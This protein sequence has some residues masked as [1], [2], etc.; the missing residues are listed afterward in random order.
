[1]LD[2]K[3]IRDSLDIVE[4]NLKRR[5]NTENIKMLNEVILLDKKWR[6]K[7]E[8]TTKLRFE[9]NKISM[10][11]SKQKKEGKNIDNLMKQAI[12]IPKELDILEKETKKIQE[13]VKNILMKLPN[14]LHDSVPDGKD[15]SQNKEIKIIGKKPEFDFKPKDHFEIL[16]DLNMIDSESGAKAAGHAFFLFKR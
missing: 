13:N 1:M 10:E 15:E 3:L 8:E 12:K 11:I 4:K 7:L 16:K 14:L 5:N 9:R 6:E 2:I